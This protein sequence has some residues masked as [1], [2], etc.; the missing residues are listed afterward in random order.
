[1]VKYQQFLMVQTNRL[2]SWQSQSVFYSEYCSLTDSGGL[3]GTGQDGKESQQE[4]DTGNEGTQGCISA[5]GRILTS[6]QDWRGS[7]GLGCFCVLPSAGGH[8]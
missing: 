6:P 2:K 5:E 4:G 1:M 7:A 3:E 8:R